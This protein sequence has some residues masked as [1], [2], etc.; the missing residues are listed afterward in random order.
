MEDR[1][2]YKERKRKQAAD[3]KAKKRAREGGD[4]DSLM[5]T[6]GPGLGY[7]STQP[8][9]L[10]SLRPLEDQYQEAFCMQG[11]SEIQP[12]SIARKCWSGA[13]NCFV[14]WATGLG[15]KVLFEWDWYREPRI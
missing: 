7:P 15:T 4:T 1:K 5:V 2:D 3:A 9:K 12:L 13:H 6:L 10:F 11:R 8:G 14:T